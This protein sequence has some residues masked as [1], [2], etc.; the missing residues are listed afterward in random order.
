MSA[1]TFPKSILYYVPFTISNSEATA[2]PA[3]F[4]QYVNVNPSLY[5]AYLASNLSNVQWFDASGNVISSW[6][7]SGNSNT[8]TSAVYWLK[9]ANGIP[10]SSS[11]TV[12]MGLAATTA[13]LFNNTTTGEAPQLSGTYGEYDNGTVVFSTLYD[14]FAG[15]SLGSLWN[16]QNGGVTKFAVNNSLQIVSDYNSTQAS[17]VSKSSFSV[18]AI[19]EAYVITAAWSAGGP[20]LRAMCVADTN[21][22]TSCSYGGFQY[23]NNYQV[24]DN[25]TS[26]NNPS[27][28][29]GT[30]ACGGANVATSTKSM[31]GVVGIAWIATGS[32]TTYYN[33]E[34]DL[35]ATDA[36]L[37]APSDFYIY[38]GCGS[39]GGG[40][41]GLTWQW[42]RVRAL[43]P[44]NA[45]PS[46]TAGSLA[47]VSAVIVPPAIKTLR[48]NVAEIMNKLIL[49]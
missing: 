44:S 1:P 23:G 19:A 9:I 3:P 17:V 39:G 43:P 13:N 27:L 38:M 45:M 7:E 4:Q 28:N 34:V 41:G 40:A 26:S 22:F 11:I 49:P 20:T 29:S 47:K 21:T 18:P 6:L 14:N 42:V 35:V 30:S 46:Q 5:T 12:Y 24:S 36:S 16:S 31:P 25:D 15:T 8:A 48:Y 2:T 33:D 32:E 37:T 10:A